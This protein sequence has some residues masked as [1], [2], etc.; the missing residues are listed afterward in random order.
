VILLA[1]LLRANTGL[2]LPSGAEVRRLW[3]SG[4][5]LLA[6]T[7]SIT[8]ASG[9]RAGARPRV[10][11]E[12]LAFAGV[13]VGALLAG[14]LPFYWGHTLTQITAANRLQPTTQAFDHSVTSSFWSLGRWIADLLFLPRR[15]DAALEQAALLLAIPS[16]WMEV[17]GLGL[18]AL[19]LRLL[20]DLRRPLRLPL[21]LAAIYAAWMLF[22]CLF[23][24]LRTWYLIP[25]VGL[26][27][28]TPLGRPV[29]RFSLALTASIQLEIFFLSQAP[30]FGGWQPWTAVLVVVIPLAVLLWE[31]RRA[32]APSPLPE[33]ERQA[34]V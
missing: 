34:G 30:P 22:F 7:K 12:W 29:R 3:S 2:R 21:A 17:L 9:H 33:A 11:R 28:L 8:V 31:L 26:V 18:L 19:T 15:A 27:C 24:L 5:R 13:L 20:S 14:Y 25:L 23:H 32:P 4:G 1:L 10:T 6:R 16:L